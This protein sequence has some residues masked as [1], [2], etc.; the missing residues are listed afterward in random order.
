[1]SNHYVVYLKLIFCMCYL[2][3]LIIVII[4]ACLPV[5][6]I[7]KTNMIST[8]KCLSSQTTRGGRLHDKAGERLEELEKAQEGKND[9]DQCCPLEI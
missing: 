4:I 9:L 2:K 7:Q 5:R 3:S 1:M 6:V 8:C